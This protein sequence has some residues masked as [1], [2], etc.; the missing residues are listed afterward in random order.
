MANNLLITTKHYLDENKKHCIAVTVQSV[1]EG[2]SL[3]FKKKVDEIVVC[4]GIVDS[5]TNSRFK[6]TSGPQGCIV[7][8]LASGYKSRTIV[9]HYENKGRGRLVDQSG[10]I[11]VSARKDGKEIF[12]AKKQ[13]GFR[14][15]KDSTGKFAGIEMILS[16]TIKEDSGIISTLKI[17][18]PPKRL[19]PAM[20]DNTPDDLPDGYLEAAKNTNWNVINPRKDYLIS[21]LSIRNFEDKDIDFIP[22]LKKSVTAGCHNKVKEIKNACGNEI[23]FRQ[24]MN[25]IRTQVRKKEGAYG[26]LELENAAL[27]KEN[28]GLKKEN[29]ELK[30]ENQS[31]E[32]KRNQL[33]RL[34][35]SRHGEILD[36]KAK[37]SQLEEQKD[38]DIILVKTPTV[39]EK[40]KAVFSTRQAL[41]NELKE[42]AIK[43]RAER[44][45]DAS[46]VANYCAFYIFKGIRSNHV[47]KQAME[48]RGP[49]GDIENDLAYYLKQ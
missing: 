7:H 16:G 43:L 8:S 1:L 20:P 24:V 17:S 14:I 31:L 6:N 12:G 3:S 15:K 33:S 11:R 13:I 30:R 36:L 44:S 29:D 42:R 45:F 2:E 35:V 5:Y 21:V 32:E 25:E 28:S 9:F 48:Y 41:V 47:L 34:A 49:F 10:F 4:L 27:E 40:I 38:P 18:K 39:K 26:N 23:T 19:P 46:R 22:Q 37:V